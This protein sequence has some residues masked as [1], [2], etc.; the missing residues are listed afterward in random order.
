[1]I[2]IPCIVFFIFYALAVK[3]AEANLDNKEPHHPLDAE[4]NLKERQPG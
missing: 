4:V 1:M 3:I 2:K